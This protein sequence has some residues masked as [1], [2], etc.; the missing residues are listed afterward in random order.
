MIGFKAQT[1]LE[2]FNRKREEKQKK[3]QLQK[4]Q[5]DINK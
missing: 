1:F 3:T 2:G 4:I 5:L